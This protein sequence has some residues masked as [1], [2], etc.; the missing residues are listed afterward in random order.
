MPNFQRI[1]YYESTPNFKKYQISSGTQITN[2]LQ[3][4]KEHQIFK[5]TQ[6]MNEPHIL[7]D[8]QTSKE[9]QITIEPQILSEIVIINDPKF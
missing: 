8:H 5:Q 4:L 6:I 2:E 9:S 7:K 3:I 1:P